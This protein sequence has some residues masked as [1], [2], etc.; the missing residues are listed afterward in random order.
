M[1]PH[2]R[3]MVSPR[4]CSEHLTSLTSE[5]AERVESIVANRLGQM[6]KFAQSADKESLNKKAEFIA[7]SLRTDFR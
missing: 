7:D 4:F 1:S 3:M 2:I 5:K 6:E